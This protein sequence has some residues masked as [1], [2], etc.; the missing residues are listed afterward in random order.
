MP[1]PSPATWADRRRGQGRL[2]AA[3]LCQRGTCAIRSS[4]RA[5]HLR[6]RRPHRQCASIWKA[7]APA[8]DI[9]APDIYNNDAAAYLKVI[10]LYHR[11]D[12]ALF[13]P[14]TAALRTARFFF[15]A[16]GLQAIGYSP[17]G[18]DYTRTNHPARM[19][20]MNRMLS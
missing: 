1:G 9:L 10:E 17:F 3:A 15:S 5:R 6:E 13:I 14:E 16:L 4:R 7:E 19:I 12:N 11:P 2:P 18:L 20:P 8:I